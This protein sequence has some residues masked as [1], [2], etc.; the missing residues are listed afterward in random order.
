MSQEKEIA[1]A[2]E[3]FVKAYNSGDLDS[4]LACYGDDLIKLRQGTPAETKAEVAARV[5][6]VFAQFHSQVDV[7]VDEILVSGNSAFTRGSLI[8]TLTPKAGGES[9][10]IE[11]RYLEIWRKED[12]R[13]LVV[14]TMDNSA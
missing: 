10:T 12:G 7:T 6:G 3:R 14:R 5:A 13:W 4:M 11:R 1:G 8:V 2:I 9:Q